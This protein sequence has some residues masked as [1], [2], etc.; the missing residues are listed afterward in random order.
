MRIEPLR[1]GAQEFGRLLSQDRTDERLVPPVA[2]DEQGAE[3]RCQVTDEP[4]LAGR[5]NLPR[6]ERR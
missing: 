4:E 5:G 3:G 1:R 2:G 6:V